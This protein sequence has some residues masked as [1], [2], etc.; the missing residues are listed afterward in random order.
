MNATDNSVDV[1]TFWLSW[2]NNRLV[3][4]RQIE[5]DVRILVGAA[6]HA[7][8]AVANDVTDFVTIGRVIGD[9]T[10]VGRRD[11]WRV[12]VCV[13]QAFTGQR[14]ATSSCTDHETAR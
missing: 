6:I 14:G 5:H 13:L 2:L 1:N 9:D 10:C 8:D 11:D 7:L 3:I 4:N 12:T